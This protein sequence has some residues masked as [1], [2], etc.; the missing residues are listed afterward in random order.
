MVAEYHYHSV[1]ARE[2]RLAWALTHKVIRALIILIGIG[3]IGFGVAFL[4]L[5]DAFCWVC[6]GLA[7]IPFM[8]SFWI[9]NELTRIPI[10]KHETIN[11]VLSGN[12]L[13]LLGTHPTPQSLV[14]MFRK[15]KSGVFMMVRFGI[16][17]DVLAGIAGQLTQDINPVFEKALEIRKNTNS[18]QINGGILLVAL[19]ESYPEHENILRQMKL[20]VSDLHQGIIWYN[21]L[22]GL[23]AGAKAPRRSGGIARDFSFGF[24]PTLQRYG[25]N[26]SRERELA[27]KTQILQG[28]RQEIIN[29]MVETFSKEGRQNIA[30][31]G[32]YGSGRTTIVNAFAE[33]LLDADSNIPSNLKFRQVFALDA[34]ALIGSAKERGDLESLVAKLFNEAYAA[35]NIII[36]LDNAHLF[37]EDDTGSADISNVLLPI[38]EAGKTRI[39]LEMD[40]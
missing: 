14:S 20:E 18:E 33:I 36:C 1:R 37:F 10:G 39:I 27:A 12:S 15:T 32:P 24:I 4:I 26:I 13:S 19:I 30:L 40:Q 31:V 21:Y 38:L 28:A 6:F 7:I 5:K 23:V 35:K 11:D 3:L 25:K 17:E 8:V 2:A 34:T 9:K 22:Y 29:K 16:R